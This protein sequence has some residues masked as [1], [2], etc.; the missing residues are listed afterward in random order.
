M[1]AVEQRIPFNE[2]G[3]YTG[4]ITVQI[5]WS[6]TPVHEEK[7]E[8]H[9]DVVQ[10]VFIRAISERLSIET[11]AHRN[12]HYD[13]WQKQVDDLTELFSSKKNMEMYA[14]GKP[15]T[16]EEVEKLV[17]RRA[18]QALNG[19]PFTAFTITENVTRKIIG[20]A[21]IGAG[22]TEGESQTGLI[23][24]HKYHGKKY[25]K[26]TICL[27]ATLAQQFF[28]KK[29]PVNKKAVERFTVTTLDTNKLVL[30][31]INKLGLERFGAVPQRENY[32]KDPRTIYGVRAENIEEFL[33]EKL[34]A[35]EL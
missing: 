4:K 9:V 19:N 5:D 34:L 32:S 14:D 17:D 28:E 21:S 16:K 25:G 29:Y 20:T 26:E 6:D 2:E 15:K 8:N 27:L 7:S 24:D 10:S 22:Y 30:Q 33:K 18:D 11:F 3:R 1:N 12:E 31:W 23:L 13:L 35:K